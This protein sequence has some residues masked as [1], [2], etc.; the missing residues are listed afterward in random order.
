MCVQ[1][2]ISFNTTKSEST[3]ACSFYCSLQ[4][5]KHNNNEMYLDFI[6]FAKE[7]NVSFS[8][9]SHYSPIF[10]ENILLAEK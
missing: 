4:K 6:S 8:V 10:R 1:L 9:F 5:R 3:Q 7:I 2:Y